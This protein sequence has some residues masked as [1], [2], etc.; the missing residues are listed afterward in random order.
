MNKHTLSIPHDGSDQCRPGLRNGGH[1]I[2]EEALQVMEEQ[3]AGSEDAYYYTN[4]M[5]IHNELF[6]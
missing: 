2:L 3:Y 1:P 6:E 5:R 4:G